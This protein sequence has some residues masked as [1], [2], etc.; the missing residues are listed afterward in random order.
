MS[1]FRCVGRSKSPAP[2]AIIKDGRDGGQID[3]Q[4]RTQGPSREKP[5]RDGAC[6]TVEGHSISLAKRVLQLHSV[7]AEHP[8]GT[9]FGLG[10]PGLSLTA[11]HALDGIPPN[12]IRVVSV[13]PLANTWAVGE[14]QRHGAT[15]PSPN[16]IWNVPLVA[17]P[18]PATRQSPDS[19][20]LGRDHRDQRTASAA[21]PRR[22]RPS[23]W[24]LPPRGRAADVQGTT[25]VGDGLVPSRC[26][27]NGLS[28][29]RATTR[30]APTVGRQPS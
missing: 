30:V 13:G 20:A 28:A 17:G 8:V 29:R 3:I 6:R 4:A 15:L 21:R 10:R 25:A 27:G 9:C 24:E 16:G 22:V 7:E 19:V 12:A 11:A 2:C 18:R 23:P 14:I 1:W 5:L 26:L